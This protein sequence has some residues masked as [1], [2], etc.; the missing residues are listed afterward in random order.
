[1]KRV[2]LPIVEFN[3]CQTRLRGTRLGPKFALD[4]SFICAGGQ[5]GIDTCQGDGGAPL[6]CPRGSTRE[7]RYQQTGIVAWGIGC[8]DEVPAAYANVALV[9]GWIDQQMLTNGFGTAVYTA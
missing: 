8:N 1:M 6:A 9:R 3:S 7:S 2:P 5:R 4:R